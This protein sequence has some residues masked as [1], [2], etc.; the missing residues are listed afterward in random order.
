MDPNQVRMALIMATR[1]QKYLD[2]KKRGQDAERKQ[3]DEEE[4]ARPAPRA[5]PGIAWA[6]L[7]WA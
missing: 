7:A 3:R 4:E 6:R 2:E 1:E 5:S